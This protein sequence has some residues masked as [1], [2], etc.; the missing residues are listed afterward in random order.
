M[1]NDYQSYVCNGVGVVFSAIQTNEVLSWISWIITLLATL[2]SISFTLWKWYRK[3]K[4]DGKI[5][6]EEID[7]L[8]DIID[9]ASEKLKGD[10]NGKTR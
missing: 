8:G 4:E 7:E 2:L 10:N 5:T 1:Q 3:A 6:K 9:D